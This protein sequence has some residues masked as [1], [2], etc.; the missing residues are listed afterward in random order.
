[1]LN[2]ARNSV[3]AGRSFEGLAIA[4]KLMNHARTKLKAKQLSQ[5]TGNWPA[6]QNAHCEW[7]ARMEIAEDFC[8][9]WLIR[10]RLSGDGVR[11][12]FVGDLSLPKLAAFE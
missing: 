9:S 4:A 3:G 5:G 10:E 8:V 12:M 11:A 1:M 6:V 2:V 7:N